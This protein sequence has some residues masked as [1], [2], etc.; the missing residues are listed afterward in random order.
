MSHLQLSQAFL[1][2]LA[3]L[4]GCTDGCKLTSPRVMLI[5]WM[6]IDWNRRLWANNRVLQARVCE[7]VLTGLSNLETARGCIQFLGPLVLAT[8]QICHSTLFSTGLKDVHS[9]MPCTPEI[10]RW[11]LDRNSCVGLVTWTDR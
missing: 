11:T 1:A 9:W 6:S 5:N 4:D 2:S 10:S 8:I 7:K 3:L